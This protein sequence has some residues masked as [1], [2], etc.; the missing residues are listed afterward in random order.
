M[1]VALSR[2]RKEGQDP[3][4]PKEPP[5]GQKLEYGPLCW[6]AVVS[7][8]PVRPAPH[9]PPRLGNAAGRPGLGTH[10]AGSQAGPRRLQTRIPA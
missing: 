5:G 2:A 6:G 1:E 8:P 9:P 10:G 7:A 4:G 3:A